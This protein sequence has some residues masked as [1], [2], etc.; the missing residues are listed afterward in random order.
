[1]SPHSR[2]T[3]KFRYF[4]S[5]ALAAVLISMTLICQSAYAQKPQLSL[6]D[7]LIALRSSKASLPEKNKILTEAVG[8]RGITFSLSSEIEKE[9]QST[10][11][12][13]SLIQAIKSKSVIVPAAMVVVPKP[14]PTPQATPAP[15][16]ASFYKKRGNSYLAKGEFDLAVNEFNKV[17]EMKEENASV[18]LNRGAAYAGRN[19]YDLAISDFDKSINLDPSQPAAYVNRGSSYEKSG[20]LKKATADYQK[21]LELDTAN[22]SAKSGLA[23][24]E[25]E[26]AKLQPKPVLPQPAATVAAPASDVSVPEML[27]VGQINSNAAR[28]AMPVYPQTARQMRIQ[29]KVVV[30]ITLDEEG[31]I[32]SAK[33]TSGPG[34]LRAA[35]EDAVR[36]SKFDP[37][38]VG[39]K[40]V[41]AM[42]FVVFNFVS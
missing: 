26:L 11:A 5:S 19:R 18:Y 41:K 8:E 27:N 30:Q 16:E 42:G 32:L 28:L 21:A 23:R 14:D 15:P 40:P 6:A 3:F 39:D 31:K 29:G 25:T 35:S 7:L 34:A 37:A 17:F 2:A 1:M 38:K 20:D 13:T 9:L 24:I 10:G 12:D 4:L 22:E 33:A 36:K